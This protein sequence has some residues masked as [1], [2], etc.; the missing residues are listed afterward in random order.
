MNNRHPAFTWLTCALVSAPLPLVFA[1]LGACS[2]DVSPSGDTIDDTSPDVDSAD[3]SDDTATPDTANPPD[4]TPDVTGDTDTA[5][6]TTPTPTVVINEVGAAGEPTDW[7]ELFN[8]GAADVDLSG[9]LFRDDDETHAFTFPAGSLLPA[10]GYKVVARDE[11]GFDFGLGT[12]DAALLYDATGALIDQTSWLEGE[13]PLGRS[14]GRIPNGSGAFQTLVAPT[15][16]AINVPNPAETCGNGEIEGFEVCDGAAFGAATCKDFGWGGG[17]LSCL[18]NCGVIGQA[19]CSPRAAGLVINEVESDET[20]RIELYNGGA[21][22]VTVE[23]YTVTDAA[24]NAYVLGVGLKIASGGHLLLTRDIDHTFGLGDADG[25]TLTDRDGAVVDQI[26]WPAG[27]AV[28]S[29]CRIPDGVGGF[30]TCDAQSFGG[31]NLE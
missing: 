4:T 1:P 30:R 26:A 18:S 25:L 24:G 2:D 3:S 16:G 13:S 15:P 6:D 10:G 11:A 23:G 29:Y 19:T 7:V 5:T 22:G 12:A 31:D 27:A 21:S 17:T 28:P 8:P 9:W 20:D 14:W